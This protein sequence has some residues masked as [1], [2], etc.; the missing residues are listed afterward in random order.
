MSFS[1]VPSKISPAY[2]F[3]TLE[4][5]VLG[6]GYA[7]EDSSTDTVPLITPGQHRPEA[8]LR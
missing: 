8:V 4:Q 6:R 5:H 3:D 1:C 2:I 7:I